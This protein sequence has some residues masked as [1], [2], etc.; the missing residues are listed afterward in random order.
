MQTEL[1]GKLV[2]KC[3]LPIW[4]GASIAIALAIATDLHRGRAAVLWVM[5]IALWATYFWPD[6]GAKKRFGWASP[7][8]SLAG[9]LIVSAAA[10]L[11]RLYRL[12]DFPLGAFVD[13]IFTLNSTLLQLE[14]PF[15]P[16]GHTLAVSKAWGSDH[17]NLLLYLNL[18]ILKFFGVNYWSTKLLPVIPGVI[19]CTV[20]FLIAQRIFDKR[21]AL[22]TAI[23]FATA[24]WS[25]R[26]SRYG[27][28]VSLMIMLFALAISLLLIAM[29]SGRIFYSYGAGIAAGVS[30]YSYLGARVAVVSLAGF[31][32]WECVLRR[33]QSMYRQ[34]AAF[35]VGIMIAAYPFL[36][37]YMSDVTEFWARTS[38][39]S[40]FNH[41]HPVQ[42]AL[43]NIAPHALMFH[44]KG[45]V[46]ARDNFP[47]LPMID[48][49]SG[50]LLIAGVLILVRNRDT[51]AR[52]IACIFTLNF[53]G[54]IFSLSQEGAPYIYRTAALIVPA[55]L[56]IGVG[57]Q[58]LWG[59]S[60][61]RRVVL[62]VASMVVLNF[63]F[64]FG[65][66]SQNIAAMRVMS[67]ESRLIGAE[68]A[69]DDQPVW[70]VSP[71]VLSQTELNAK[72]AEKYGNANPAV[73]FP[74]VLR[75][76]AIINFS[77]RYDT[78]QTLA[79]NLSHPKG[80]YFVEASALN[81]GP[82]ST[83]A[84]IIFNS[85]NQEMMEKLN[86]L[87]A[88]I[89]PVPDILGEPLLTVAE[90]GSQPISR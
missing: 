34:A 59:K 48:P 39:V 67:Y 9:L 71:D 65:L 29:Q 26:L 5:A 87:G 18:P 64:Y 38:E 35:G 22:A 54:G 57:V 20:V 76:L 77:G 12:A 69:R 52:L 4:A 72:P 50:L 88:S 84:K 3:S 13:E 43:N 82:P 70:L 53:L 10:A 66:E 74:P 11:A 46:F 63:Y 44:W 75:K 17:A 19:A 41:E 68:V 8:F 37:Y 89:R 7:S 2:K 51:F 81:T 90:F 40:V 62:L 60:A 27:W 61:A 80:M 28:D 45:G 42:M 14:Q 49:L 33:D 83:P 6:A 86:G 23:L 1:A 78:R 30:L 31:L 16:F 24:H 32:V 36:C 55:F 47:G 21:V 15:D 73:L 58:W 56:T 79:E 85:A 25:V